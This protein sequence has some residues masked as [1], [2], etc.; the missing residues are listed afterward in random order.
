[1]KF[2]YPHKIPVNYGKCP[3]ASTNVRTDNDFMSLVDIRKISEPEEPAVTSSRV[4]ITNALIPWIESEVWNPSWF[5]PITVGIISAF[6]TLIGLLQISLGLIIG[7]MAW[8]FYTINKQTRIIFNLVRILTPSI[9]SYPHGLDDTEVAS[10]ILSEAK[11][12]DTSSFNV[13]KKLKSYLNRI[14]APGGIANSTDIC[15]TGHPKL[16]VHKFNTTSTE[17]WQSVASSL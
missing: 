16:C 17:F 15:A 5:S 8:V 10:L 3:L 14:F 7:Y 12:Y 13:D 1:M 2:Y 6:F 4:K 11:I 9:E